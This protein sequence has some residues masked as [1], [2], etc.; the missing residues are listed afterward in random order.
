MAI[1]VEAQEQRY[2]MDKS[3]NLHKKMVVVMEVEKECWT[4]LVERES[5]RL[6]PRRD[7]LEDGSCGERWLS[8]GNGGDDF[9]FCLLL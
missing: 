7:L 9:A 1:V 8:Q 5:Q 2:R 6:L 4:V 3:I